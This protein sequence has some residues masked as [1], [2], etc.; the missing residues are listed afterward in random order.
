[1]R[2]TNKIVRIIQEQNG[3][4]NND[5][6]DLFK[7]IKRTQHSKFP[8]QVT[9]F[10]LVMTFKCFLLYAQIWHTHKKNT[11]HAVDNMDLSFW[12]QASPIWL[13]S[14]TCANSTLNSTFFV[15]TLSSR[16]NT[17]QAPAKFRLELATRFGVYLD[18]SNICKPMYPSCAVRKT[19]PSYSSSSLGMNWVSIKMILKTIP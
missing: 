1:M 9:T 4:I 17:N 10:G 5:T 8:Y 19:K 13:K 12:N 18:R 3:K 14:L 11:Q 2:R 6:C 7:Q 16:L 15:C